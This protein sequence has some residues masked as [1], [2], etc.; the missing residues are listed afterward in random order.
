[1]GRNILCTIGMVVLVISSLSLGACTQQPAP[2]PLPTPPVTN[3]QQPAPSPSPTPPPAVISAPPPAEQAALPSISDVVAK[4]KPSVVAINVE[5]TTY[6]IF[7]QPV[8]AQGAGAGWVI[9]SDGYI[10]TNNHVVEGANTI[11]VT[12]DDG[13]TIPA[14][15]A[16]TD[17]FSD[18]AI[19]KI[20]AQ[21]LPALSP[22]D[23]FH[24][25]VGDWV[26]AVGNALGQGISATSGI[27]SALGISIS[28]SPGQTLHNLIQTDA[29]I[30]PGNS[31][32]P[33]V[34][35]AGQ[36][37]GINSIKVSQIGVEGMGYAISINE[38]LP[39][40]NTLI[41]TGYVL[42][43]WLG[44]SVF[45]ID[46]NVASFYGLA[47]AQGVLITDVA[48]GSPAEKAGLR[49]GDIITAIDGK[50]QVDDGVLMDYINSLKI[51]QTIQ[52]TYY[53][54]NAQNTV[55][56]TLAESPKA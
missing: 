23:S 22:G 44:I 54:R 14:D 30:N 16:F 40:I 31:G 34:N 53:R 35:M 55:S 43:P 52:I 4:V 11:M 56:V 51:G 38:A 49:A 47:V 45:T 9:R 10:V 8:Q 46:Q 25:N 2:G 41:N 27:I 37:I 6:G 28:E 42:R 13:R 26:V 21:N 36:V 12:L 15:K 3:S 1:M 33:L 17:P 39:I 7:N 32:G 29:A 5:I 24:S 20:N 18:L 19:V 48:A 50:E